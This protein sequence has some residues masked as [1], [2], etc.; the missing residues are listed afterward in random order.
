MDLDMGFRLS[1]LAFE[2][3]DSTVSP[4]LAR[5]VSRRWLGLGGE[6]VS[7]AVAN[8]CC[9]RSDWVIPRGLWGRK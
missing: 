4:D 3:P 8:G 1:L 7:A 9:G 6:W 2:P 5:S